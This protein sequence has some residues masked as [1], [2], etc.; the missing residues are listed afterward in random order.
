MKKTKDIITPDQI[1]EIV[2]R[3]RWYI[4]LPFIVSM[5]VGCFFAITLPK[6][7]ESQTLILVDPQRVPTN[8][9]QSVVSQ[10]IDARINT[11]RQQIMSRSNLEKIIQNFELFN[12]PEQE[13][14]FFEDKLENLRERI[15][16]NITRARQGADAFSI[17]FRG[18]DPEK[19]M[20]VANSLASYII[21][22]NLKVRES[23]AIGTSDF[24]DA[25]LTNMRKK[26][27]EVEETLKQYQ[28]RYMGELPEQLQTNLSILNRLQEQITD[29]RQNLRDVKARLGSVENQ[30]KIVQT[31]LETTGRVETLIVEPPEQETELDILKRQLADLKTRYT[32]RHPDVLRIEKRIESLEQEGQKDPVIP[33]GTPEVD[34]VQ[35]ASVNPVLN[36][37]MRQRVE[38]QNEAKTAEIEINDLLSQ[39]K[40]YEQRIENT[41]KREQDLLSLNRDYQNI[42]T[43]YNSLLSRKLE[44]D[45]SVNMEKKQK[46][47]QFRIIDSARL[48]E[49]PISPN[50]MKLFMLFIGAGLGVGGGIVFLLEYLDTSIRKPEDLEALLDM[51]VLCTVPRL[52]H[53][54]ARRLQLLNQLL[55]VISV[56]I[57]FVLFAGFAVLSF[58]GIDKTIAFIKRFID[59]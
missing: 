27:E 32:D 55:S 38:L 8:Y 24:L 43:T 47:E 4:I 21:D 56:G 30:I 57:S 22:E 14:M 11:I 16:V 39:M 52:L 6:I 50:M 7:Y 13:N 48:P 18:K 19:V 29:R 36:E 35:P 20:R 2:L 31:Q 53:K 5:I 26:L 33:R 42:Q 49:K 40:F 3:R 37:Y 58:K 25:E 54:K 12:E 1:I 59:I 17:A 15:I 44:S 46:G 23:Q 51:P 10:D 34:T 9:V 45:I 28:I 41:P